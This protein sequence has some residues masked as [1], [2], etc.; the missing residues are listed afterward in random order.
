MNFYSLIE[1]IIQLKPTNVA[2]KI[3]GEGSSISYAE[4]GKQVSRYLNTLSALGVSRGD[5]IVVQVD[6]SLP[7]LFLYLAC[8]KGGCVFIPLNTAYKASELI[9]FISD[10]EPKL[11]VTSNDRYEEISALV[12]DVVDCTA[13][14]LAGDA[15]HDLSSSS[16]RQPEFAETRSTDVDEIAVIIYTSGTT[17]RSKGAMVTH[18]N[19]ISN[20]RALTR[21]WEFS[22]QDVLLHALPIFHVHGLFVANHCALSVGA[23][24]HWIS[25]FDVDAIIQAIPKSTVMMGVPTFYTRL[26]GHKA[27]TTNL[28][29]TMRLFISGSAPLLTVTHELFETVTGHRILERYGMSEAGMITSNPYHGERKVGTVGLPLKGVCIRIVNDVDADLTEGST[30]HV[31]IKG[32][33][34][35][36]GYRNMAEKTREEFTEDGW[37]RTGDLGTL[38]SEKY[39]TIVGR[40]KDLI[41]T[42]GYNVYPKEIELVLDNE[43]AIIESAVFGLQD[44][45]FGEIVS[46]AI[47]VEPS[48]KLEPDQLIGVLKTKLASYKVPKKVYVVSQLPRNAM[49]KVQKS[50]LRDDYSSD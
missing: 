48:F 17:G 49:G 47:V 21:L 36:A 7:S 23:T 46:A 33:N 22:D 40:S 26:L 8:L 41:I 35:F 43:P 12:D 6:K 14:V 38:D 30:G 29:R 31:Q 15:Y 18:N 37:F 10:A 27:L 45:D 42:G 34:L 13:V 32:P 19:L 24:I 39:L 3:D 2:I 11:F 25:R 28:C 16:Q 44:S 4:L 9:Y 20:V 5:R 1:D 50:I